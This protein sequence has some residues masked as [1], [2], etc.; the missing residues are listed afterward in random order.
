MPLGAIGVLILETGI[1]RGW[2]RAAAAGLGAALVDFTYATVAVLAGAAVSGV[3]AGHERT[4]RVVGAIVLVV[5]AGVGLVRGLRRKG[6]AALPVAGPSPVGY[7]IRFIGLTAINPMT[8]V[9]F[10]AVVASLADQLTT[11][12]TRIAFVLGVGVAS[13]SWQLGLASAGAL[14]GAKAR[15]AVRTGLAVAG[16]GV[17]G[18][19]ALALLLR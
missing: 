10:A 19:L 15:P 6:D 1:S 5:V 3:L 4:V 16:Y 12:A 17:V 7:L 18:G 13:A 8:V 9:Y 14:L 11:P 2:R